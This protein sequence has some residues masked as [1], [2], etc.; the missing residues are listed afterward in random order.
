MNNS[1]KISQKFAF[2]SPQNRENILR[3]LKIPQLCQS[4]QNQKFCRNVLLII[5]S[6]W[7]YHLIRSF[8]NSIWYGYKFVINNASGSCIAIH[9]HVISYTFGHSFSYSTIYD[10]F[11]QTPCKGKGPD[12]VRIYQRLFLIFFSRSS[13]GVWEIL[14]YDQ[15]QEIRGTSW[16][17]KRGSDLFLSVE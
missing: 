7:S 4:L 11:S 13:H 5:N 16:E 2:S 1:Q 17:L 8:L 6:N 12:I 10:G 9:L 14:I 15:E 3:L